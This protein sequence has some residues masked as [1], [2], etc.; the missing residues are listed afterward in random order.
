MN[1]KLHEDFFLEKEKIFI[2]HGELTASLFK[3]ESGVN[4]VRIKNKFG[5]FIMLPFMGQMIWEVYF[6]GRF[7]GMKTMYT[8]PKKA[9][10]FLYT[11]GCFLM[12]CGA[13]RMGCPGPE[14]DYP[15]HGELPLASYDNI[16]IITGE[17][18]KGK[19]MSITGNYEY[20]RAFGDIYCARPIVVLREESTL[21]DISMKIENQSNYPMELMYMSHIN[22]RPV[23]NCKILQCIDWSPK[24]MEIRS[25]IPTHIKVSDEFIKFLEALK[26]NPQKTQVIRPEDV[27][28][29]EIAFFMKKP[30]M[31]EEGWTHFMNMHPNGSADYVRYKPEQ[32]D[33]CTRWISRTKNQ[34]GLGLAL[35][36][37]CDPEGYTA[38]KLKGNIKNIVG[39]S[40]ITFSMTAGYLGNDAAVLMEKNIE[41]ILNK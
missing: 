4:A 36:A 41:R 38:E 20:N 27:Y 13:L 24:N 11:Y 22:F 12:H 29:P 6:G 15:I 3:Y 18:E 25:V 19:Y 14:D 35:P 16:E 28:N 34:E 33:H 10:N 37:T 26:T 8:Q 7:L 23:E 32:L 21:I 30:K 17:D 40:S 5:Y 9:S 2:N 31:D 39:K 1:C